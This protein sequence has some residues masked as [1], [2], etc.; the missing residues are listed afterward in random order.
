MEGTDKGVPCCITVK[1]G[2]E[3]PPGGKKTWAMP[4]EEIQGL[5]LAIQSL[6]CWLPEDLNTQSHTHARMHSS[7]SHSNCLSGL[8]PTKTHTMSRVPGSCVSCVQPLTVDQ[9]GKK[10][11]SRSVYSSF[12]PLLSLSARLT[13]VTVGA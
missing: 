8:E 9:G 5:A 12:K 3:E 10:S 7:P 2:G 11:L 6:V 4:L 1:P 13:A